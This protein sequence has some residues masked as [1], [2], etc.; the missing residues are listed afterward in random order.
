MFLFHFFNIYL[1]LSNINHNYKYFNI[2][3]LGAIYAIMNTEKIFS[4]KETVN[5]NI[6]R[7][8]FPSFNNHR[9]LIGI[10]LSIIF[11]M[12]WHELS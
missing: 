4:I 2:F 9:T 8:Q 7:V 5:K 1:N 6:E 10:I 11:R 3:L 12:G